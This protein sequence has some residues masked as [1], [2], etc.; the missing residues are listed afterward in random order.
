MDF[1]TTTLAQPATPPLPA[2]TAAFDD[3]S[4]VLRAKL[5]YKFNWTTPFTGR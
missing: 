3:K 1:G 4:H 2:S 5:N